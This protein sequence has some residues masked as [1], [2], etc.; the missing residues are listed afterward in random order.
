MVYLW[1]NMV[2]YSNRL[3][4]FAMVCKQIHLC[5]FKQTVC[6]TQQ[7]SNLHLNNI[8]PNPWTPSSRE[9]RGTSVNSSETVGHQTQL[10]WQDL[11]WGWRQWKNL[12]VNSNYTE[13]NHGMKHQKVKLDTRTKVK[14][15]ACLLRVKRVLVSMA[16]SYSVLILRRW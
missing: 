4:Y 5:N 3:Q 15:A 2:I 7:P 14:K 13:K 12:Q 6:P 8:D 9:T 10:S 11:L 1:W 16:V